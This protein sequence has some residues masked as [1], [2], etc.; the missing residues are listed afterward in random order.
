M[1]RGKKALKEIVENDSHYRNMEEDA[2]DVAAQYTNATELIEAK[3]FFKKD[4]KVDMCRAITELI[5]DGRA[6]G[7]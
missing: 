5:A 3:Y 6:D 4:G 1:L 7:I 2:Y